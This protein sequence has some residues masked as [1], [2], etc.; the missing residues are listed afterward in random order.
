MGR[1]RQT[2]C[3][4]MEI[5]RLLVLVMSAMAGGCFF[6][7]SAEPP[8]AWALLIPTVVLVGAGLLQ[9]RQTLGAQLLARAVW[10]SKLLLGTLVAL[11]GGQNEQP[12][13]ALIAGLCGMTLLL[14]G[15]TKMDAGSES[16]PISH[17]GLWVLALIMAMADTVTLLFWG[18]MGLLRGE[19]FLFLGCVTLMAVGI[20]GL[21]RLRMWGLL[22]T[23]VGNIVVA[24]LILLDSFDQ[25]PHEPLV[26][27]LSTAVLQLF[28]P[29]PMIVSIV[30]GRP[31]ASGSD[32][33][34]LWAGGALIFVLVSI[35]LL[36]GLVV[37][38]DF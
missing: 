28:V 26:L 29:L 38:A 19:G 11:C 3:V 17:R 4:T 8:I 23:L 21:L 18:M 9:F 14:A 25:L 31:V 10:W 37:H 27:L 6:F 12:Y 30:R 5:S 22:V 13:G 35:S 36:N 15:P 24:S 34:R 2:V 1:V 33:W 7:F 32:R 16:V 20:V